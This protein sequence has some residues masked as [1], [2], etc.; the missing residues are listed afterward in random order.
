LPSAVGL[1][2]ARMALLS[3]FVASK[4]GFAPQSAT[5]QGMLG[6]MYLT[7]SNN[8]ES[9]T[10]DEADQNA[11]FE[12]M[13][14][15]LE[16]E[17]NKFKETRARKETEKADAEAMLADTTKAYEDTEKQ[18]NADIEFFGQTKEAC[19][20]KHEEWNLREKMR[21]SE[22]DGIN[23]ALE[24]LTSDSARELF[25]DSIKPGVSMSLLQTGSV[26]SSNAP[27]NKAYKALKVQATKA[28]SMRLAMLAVQI[29]T[30]K[31]GHF[32][33]VIGA[34]DKMIQTLSDEGADDLAKKTQCLDEYQE[35]DRTVSKL[36]WNIKNNLA[37][38]D[39]L[40]K[41]IELRKGEKADTEQK[42]KETQIYIKD[43]G[44]ERKEEHEAYQQAKKDDQ[45]AVKLLE[46]AK[47]AFA[48][49]YKKQGIEMGPIQGSATGLVQEPEFERSADDAPDASFTSKGNNKN[50]SKNILS[51]FQYIIEDLN[52]ELSN[53][54][55][56]EEKSQEEY[57]AELATAEQ[58]L[59]DLKE[60]KVTLEGI[61]AK[62]IED[63][64][65]ENKDM[66]ENNKDRDSELSYQAKITP[67]CDWILKA[68]DQR[69]TA[70]AAEADGLTTAKEF[71]AGKTAL[72]QS[73]KFDDASLKSLN[74]LGLSK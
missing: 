64:K 61:I 46:A 59:D 70:R 43:I 53:G 41:L 47:A 62:R 35:I 73:S 36:D 74:F 31:A 29:R 49:F 4:A 8:L 13:Y 18:M 40:E 30:T 50:A 10:Q 34:I 39:K 26:D 21:N 5:I 67:D 69:A 3:E 32:D 37:K 38:I 63:K 20:S 9:A 14:A 6:D 72:V 65:E 17:N 48:K 52:D 19:L 57:E 1:P 55:K 7:F 22:L 28:H 15:T 51:L 42:I 71:L 25:A 23:K 56:A 11:D 16:K 2:P 44:A 27:A 12:Q 68:F 45:A 60:K 58:L 33:K 54:K 66:K 24:M